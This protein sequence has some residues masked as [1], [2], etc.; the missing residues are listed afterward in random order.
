MRHTRRQASG[1][2]CNAGAGVCCCC[3]VCVGC[4]PFCFGLICICY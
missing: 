2:S 1:S 3:A 4:V